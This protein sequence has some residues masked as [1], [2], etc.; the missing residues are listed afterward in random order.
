MLRFHDAMHAGGRYGVASVALT[1][2]SF[3]P[4]DDLPDLH[5]V[6]SNSQYIE[7][8]T[9]ESPAVPLLRHCLGKVRWF[10]QNCVNGNPKIAKQRILET[11]SDPPVSVL[12]GQRK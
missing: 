11:R 9:F 2:P 10:C 12:K 3:H 1:N 7:R 6:R 5:G 8:R 4:L